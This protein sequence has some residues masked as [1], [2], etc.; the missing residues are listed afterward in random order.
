[1][2]ISNVMNSLT[3]DLRDIFHSDRAR[4]ELRNGILM[5]VI[6]FVLLSYFFYHV[7]TLIYFHV[8]TLDELKLLSTAGLRDGIYD[9]IIQAVY[10]FGF[11]IFLC[12]VLMFLIGVHV[13]G[14]L[15]RP[16][17][18]LGNYCEKAIQNPDH[19]YEDTFFTEHRLMS[20]FAEF[21]FNH[22][23]NVKSLEELK[24]I[25]IPKQYLG[26]HDPKLEKS[27]LLHFFLLMMV[28][29][30]ATG[31]MILAVTEGIMENV[32]EISSHLSKDMSL[33][34]S[35]LQADFMEMNL[36][37]LIVMSLIAYLVLGG[38]MYQ[39]VSGGAFA[40]FLTFRSFLKGKTDS[41][42]HLVGS[43]YLREHTRKINKYLEQQEKRILSTD[44]NRKDVS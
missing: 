30:L 33:Q 22:V 18:Y 10:D 15:I 17:Y 41:R 40:I 13:S 29:F 28:P 6:F 23:K 1:M 36:Y 7:F 14:F 21:F 42:V 27:F 19:E 34:V 39:K 2:I 43:R 26:I 8:L 32:Y 25:S 4:F 31:I 16:F 9:Y 35:A 12:F 20:R 3:K 11:K 38:T 37:S 5:M 44:G 24:E